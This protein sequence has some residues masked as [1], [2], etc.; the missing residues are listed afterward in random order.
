MTPPLTRRQ[1]IGYALVIEQIRAEVSGNVIRVCARLQASVA[2]RCHAPL[3][4]CKKPRR[5]RP[6]A[7]TSRHMRAVDGGDRPRR[8]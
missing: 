3:T 5:P 4:E 8:S 7:E 2:A 1:R 6:K